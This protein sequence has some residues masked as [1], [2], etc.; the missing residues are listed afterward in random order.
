MHQLEKAI[1]Y[2][3]GVCVNMAE[4]SGALDI[5][6]PDIFSIKHKISVIIKF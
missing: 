2:W 1:N 4:I 5:S 6:L 3:L